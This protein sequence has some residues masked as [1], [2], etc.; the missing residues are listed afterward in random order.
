MTGRTSVTSIPGP[1]PSLTGEKG[2]ASEVTP[3]LVAA[4]TQRVQHGL[5]LTG[6]R[7]RQA[8][9]GL[10]TPSRRRLAVFRWALVAERA[11]GA[12]CHDDQRSWWLRPVDPQLVSVVH[13]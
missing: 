8:C 4:M 12:D 9:G 5:G 3:C 11:T 6:R 7:F 1:G 13:T 2:W 10:P